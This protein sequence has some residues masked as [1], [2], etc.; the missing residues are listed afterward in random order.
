[1]WRMQLLCGDNPAKKWWY[2]HFSISRSHDMAVL[3]FLEAEV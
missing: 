2:G 3:A 1:M